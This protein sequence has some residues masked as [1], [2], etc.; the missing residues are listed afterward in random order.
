L[1]ASPT[2]APALSDEALSSTLDDFRTALGSEAVLTSEQ[3]MAE[4]RDPFAFATW[5]D[6]TGSAAVMPTTTEQVQEVVRIANR[7]GVPLWTHS[8]GRNNGYGGPAPRLKGSVI[9]S[10]RNMNKVL[11]INE[12]CAYA[13]VEPGVRWFDLYEAIRAGGHKLMVSIADV[14]WGSVIGNT[15]DNGVTYLPMGVDMAAQCGMEVVLANGEVMRTGMGAMPDNRAWHVYKRG[16][17]PTPDQLFM[18]SNF[19]I[20]TK[21]GYWLMPQPEV[22]MPLWLRVWNDDDLPQVVDTLRSLTLDATIRMVPQIM[23]TVLLGSVFTNR[24]DW[25]R[26]E[27]P[28]P[29]RILD[30]MARELEVGRWLMRFALYEDDAVADHKFEKI[31]RAFERIPGAEVWGEKHSP[32]DIPKLENPMEQVQGGL[33]SLDLNQMTAWYGGEEGGHIGF[34][35]VAPLT[36]SDAVA[37]RDLLRG[38]VEGAGLD[39]IASLIPTNARSF[40]HITLVIF[41]TKD[42]AQARSAYD[43]AK[44]LVRDCAKLGYGEYRAHLDFMDLAAEQYSFNHHAYRRFNERL[45]DA[46]DPNGI[47]SPGRHG[48]W[49]RS[50]RE[51][52]GDARS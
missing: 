47:L 23:N 11:E 16:L 19:G 7:R 42:E 3:D 26:E 12:E 37:L 28:I 40:I 25:W 32:E 24:T 41:D 50:M 46:L 6:Y 34:S 9:V 21:M 44:R 30:K 43:V 36:G 48:I 1:A 22:Y 33:P 14:G 10:L 29:D 38:M 8:Q 18:Q 49:P 52:G 35:P 20:V 13:V 51:N 45:K 39:Y 4:F 2:L 17:G 27:G 15:L 31:K 5:D